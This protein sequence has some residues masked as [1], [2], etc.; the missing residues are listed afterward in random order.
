MLRDP[1]RTKDIGPDLRIDGPKLGRL[2]DPLVKSPSKQPASAC[3]PVG[4]LLRKKPPAVS[5]KPKLQIS[6]KKTDGP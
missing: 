6:T 2:P 5:T 4:I 3:G 1:I